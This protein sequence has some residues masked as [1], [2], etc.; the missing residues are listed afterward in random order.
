[1]GFHRKHV[2]DS[3]GDLWLRQYGTSAMLIWNCDL[4]L[5]ANTRKGLFGPLLNNVEKM[6]GEDDKPRRLLSG[7]SYIAMTRPV[8]C[9][10]N[11]AREQVHF[12]FALCGHKGLVG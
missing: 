11:G 3:R 2:G 1:M 10:P 4:S 5:N 9:M 7:E 6:A 12:R 8:L